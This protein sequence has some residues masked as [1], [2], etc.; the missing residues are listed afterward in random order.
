MGSLPLPT[1]T[2]TWLTHAEQA[3][4]SDAQVL[5]HLLNRA[6]ARDQDVARFLDSYSATIAALCR[7]LEDLERAA[8]L[9]HSNADAKGTQSDSVADDAQRIIDH[10]AKAGPEDQDWARLF[11]A[12]TVPRQAPAATPTSVAPTPSPAA[13]A[14]IIGYE[15]PLLPDGKVDKTGARAVI[16]RVAAWLDIR[17]QHGCSALLRQEIDQ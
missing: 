16:H 7:R 1:Q 10:A 9:R 17:G 15:F 6:D 2:L 13:L 8:G 14:G 4:Q 12:A 5:L 11:S 3:G